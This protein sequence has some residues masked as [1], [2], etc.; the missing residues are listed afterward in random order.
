[1]A[2]KA[3]RSGVPCPSNFRASIASRVRAIIAVMRSRMEVS[4]AQL[5]A[6]AGEVAEGNFE[7]A[8]KIFE[9]TRPGSSEPEIEAVAEAFG[10]MAVKVEAR[11]FRI[12]RALAE[13]IR[14]NAQLEEASQIRAEF[15]T[16]AS[17]II[18]VLSLYTMSLS[19]MQNVVG[20]NLSLRR[21]SVEAISFGFLLLQIGLVVFFVMK[22]K[23]RPADYGWTLANWRSCLSES[24]LVTA[25]A[26]AVMIG[27][28]ALLVRYTAEFRNQ[29]ILDWTYWGGGWATVVAYSFVAPAQEMIGR[30]FLQNSIEKFLTGRKRTLIAVA[31]TSA[32]FGV[33]HLHFSFATGIATM[34]A[35][36]IFGA[37][38]A[39][40]RA[41]LGVSISHF[42]LGILAFGPLRLLGL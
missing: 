19:F 6:A 2:L 21:L 13:I 22:H 9:F 27:F 30:G 11:E 14:K 39:R 42:V 35:G 41:L 24:L 23:P 17:F 3:S 5:A 4:L 37:L 38:Y 12:D 40:Q 28:K 16:M 20:M 31:L 18:I 10:M 34:A 25:G 1:M 32:L 36:L 33:V 26:F 29:P 7:S 8:K 15:G